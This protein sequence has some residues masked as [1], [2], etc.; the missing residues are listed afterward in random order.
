MNI[1]IIIQNNSLKNQLEE[2]RLR[3]ESIVMSQINGIENRVSNTVRS[4]L[5][6]NEESWVKSSEFSVVENTD[7]EVTLKGHFVLNGIHED[8]ETKI[9]FWPQ[10][11]IDEKQNIA[12]IN[13]ENG[14]YVA[15][16]TFNS[17]EVYY[18]QISYK[19]DGKNFVS[20][21]RTIYMQKYSYQSYKLDYRVY[22][23]NNM[24]NDFKVLQIDLTSQ[25]GKKISEDLNIKNAYLRVN[26][27]KGEKTVNLFPNWNEER[28]VNDGEAIQVVQYDNF[29]TRA[30]IKV[31]LVKE[32]DFL[33]NQ[34]YVYI[35][36]EDLQNTE[37]SLVVEYGNGHI[38]EDK[39]VKNNQIWQ[40]FVNMS[41]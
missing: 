22:F 26:N 32:G 15:N 23:E 40:E 36:E 8:T 35:N 28:H 27:E 14:Q 18:Y 30:Y 37:F 16:M 4:I 20:E 13:E 5:R 38:R 31:P 24:D 6:D 39:I 12:L 21:P 19:Q 9:I 3:L 34:R 11:E 33:E 10:G 2:A 41:E 7:K 17:N 1:F 25:S 29:T